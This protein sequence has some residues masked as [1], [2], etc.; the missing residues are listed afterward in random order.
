MLSLSLWSGDCK[1]LWPEPP[2]RPCRQV[3]MV[4]WGIFRPNAVPKEVLSGQ[5]PALGM[6][7]CIKPPSPPPS[8]WTPGSHCISC[9]ALA[10]SHLWGPY[11]SVK[12]GPNPR[13]GL[14]ASPAAVGGDRGGVPVGPHVADLRQPRP[15][16]PGG[17][18]AAHQVLMWR[19]AVFPI[20]PPPPGWELPHT[21]SLRDGTGGAGWEGTAASLPPLPP[22]VLAKPQPISR[23][24][25]SPAPGRR[26]AGGS[27][28]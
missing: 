13:P 3:V 25:C 18:A 5:V 4:H 12:H 9:W 2:A 19:P 20:Q 14:H 6:V 1:P 28:W 8:Q 27:A 24:T 7:V 23:P 17:W 26:A 16:L 11:R 22:L 15:L 10:I 21:K